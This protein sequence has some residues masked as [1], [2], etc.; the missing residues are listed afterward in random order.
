MFFVFCITLYVDTDEIWN[1]IL[2][3]QKQGHN[4]ENLFIRYILNNYK[5]MQQSLKKKDSKKKKSI[6]IINIVYIL[7]R[8]IKI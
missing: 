6:K 4:T 8:I 7:K 1:T 5:V 3:D 2:G